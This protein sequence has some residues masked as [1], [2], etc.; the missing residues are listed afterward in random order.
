MKDERMNS[1]VI[2]ARVDPIL[3]KQV[4]AYARRIRTSRSNA[5][6]I[7]LKA[8]LAS[9]GFYAVRPPEVREDV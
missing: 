5:I 6:T 2:T 9:H 4:D 8:F 3:A 7:A 1:V